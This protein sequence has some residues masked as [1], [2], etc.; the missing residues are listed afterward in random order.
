MTIAIPTRMDF[1]G[2]AFAVFFGFIAAVL[3]VQ[4]PVV[5][6]AAVAGL[7]GLFIV[8]RRPEI[9]FSLLVLSFAIPVQKSVA[10]IPL[11][12]AD[13]IVVL[14][15]LAWPLF[16]KRKEND[17]QPFPL[18]FM[19]A[20][21]FPLILSAVLSL[22]G[23]ENVSGSLK[24][25]IRLVEW[26]MV[27]PILMASFR[28]DKSFWYWMSAVFLSVPTLFA[29]DGVVEVLNNGNSITHML[30]INPPIPSKEF[31][32]IRH[33]FDVSGRA[34]STFGGAQGLA[35]YL[36][37]M[38][39]VVI[40]VAILPPKPLFR[41]LALVSLA[42]C[43]AGLFVA[44]SRGGFLGVIVMGAVIV[45][46]TKPRFGISMLVCGAVAA[47]TGFF[48]F[49]LWFG[50]NGTITGLVPGRP[51]AVLDRLI[52][53]S[54]AFS[55]F[56]EHPLLGVGFAGFRDAVYN[57]GGIQLN[58]ELGYESLHCHNTYLEVL[59]GTGMLGFMSYLWFL[60]AC[61]RHLLKAW[62]ARTGAASDCF[63]LAA[64]GALSAYMV[65]GMVDM[66]FLQN[67]HLILVSILCLGVM[68]GRAGRA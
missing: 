20:A 28:M 45:L 55:V 49:L 58:V 24:Q 37:M 50:W 19:L 60:A 18:G 11:N 43:C 47:L 46:V 13:G 67:M 44:K 22:I 54:R 30:G 16:M 4:S 27:L 1:L 42:I 64:I 33:T 3:A 2:L 6:V 63:I 15:G 39:S 52:I 9:P 26:F 5:G 29:I 38:M 68:A 10:G 66:L 17:G 56:G 61:F 25:A 36:A 21:A 65:F 31:S 34:G 57:S 40:S 35:M 53:W 41:T 14:W 23:A 32:T 51:E 48:A 59:T 62:R 12:M 8:T 7:V